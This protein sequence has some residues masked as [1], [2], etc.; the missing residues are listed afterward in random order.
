[1]KRQKKSMLIT[2][3]LLAGTATQATAADTGAS[4]WKNP[5]VHSYT[6]GPLDICDQG[7]FHVG[8]VP[9]VTPYSDSND[10]G[11]PQQ[12]IIGQ[13]YVTFQI[14]KKRREWRGAA[15]WRSMRCD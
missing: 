5:L 15:Q 8:G 10:I 3:L 13:M 2:A 14:P 4:G 6:N 12:N 7:T 11:V 9:K 1:M